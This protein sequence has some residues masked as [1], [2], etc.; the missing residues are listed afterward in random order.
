MEN[1]KTMADITAIDVFCGIGG[2]TE[3]LKLA[4]FKVIGAIEKEPVVADV[5][6][7]NHPEV[8]LWNEDIKEIT[9]NKIKK[10]LGIKKGEL[11]LLAGCPP[12]QG[13]SSMRTNNGA[14][15]IDD[16]RNDLVFDLLRLIKDLMPRAVMMENVPGLFRDHR[17][18]KILFDLR[19]LGY[20]IDGESLQILDISRYEV[21]QRRKRMVLITAFNK[22]IDFAEPDKTSVTVRQVLQKV[23]AQGNGNDPLHDYPVKRSERI[24]KM[25]RLIPKNGGSRTD[26]PKKYRLPCHIRYPSGFRDVYG[27][28][29]WD[30]VSPT[31]TGGCINPSKGRFLHPEEDRAITLREALLLQTFRED[32][33]FPTNI[34]RDRIALMIGNALPPKFIYK[35]ALEIKKQ[36]FAFC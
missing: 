23:P 30:D 9:G 14:Y 1:V 17:M 25:I 11:G 27:R 16:E 15:F 34:A 35:H 6:R 10:A 18:K 4:G 29:K 32:Y 20:H 21:P 5:F 22:K 31:I 2:L 28:M 12:C 36:L 24:E 3:G 26:L 13:F 8:F 33:R 7:L 19:S